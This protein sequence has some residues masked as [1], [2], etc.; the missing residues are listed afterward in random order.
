ML[1]G[2]GYPRG[3]DLIS[4]LEAEAADLRELKRQFAGPEATYM[5]WLINNEVITKERRALRLRGVKN[6]PRYQ[7]E[8]TM[9]D[10]MEEYLEQSIPAATP[11]YSAYAERLERQRRPRG[12]PTPEPAATLRPIGAQAELTPEQ[13]GLMAGYQSWGAAGSPRAYSEEAITEMSDW[14]KR[15]AEHARLSQSLFPTQAKLRSNW[16]TAAQR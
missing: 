14:Q 6:V 8:P 9:P 15:W 3:I 1:G 12:M 4:R 13:M 11:Q 5:R 10:W 7:E 2:G 16:R